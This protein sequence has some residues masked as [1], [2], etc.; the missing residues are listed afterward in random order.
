MLPLKIHRFLPDRQEPS[1]YQSPMSIL[2]LISSL[3]S[4]I[5]SGYVLSQF[6]SLLTR[7]CV[8][9]YTLN[10]YL[11]RRITAF[12]LQSY[13]ANKEPFLTQLTR[14]ILV[15]NWYRSTSTCFHVYSREYTCSVCCHEFDTCRTG[16]ELVRFHWYVS[17]REFT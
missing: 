17:S 7:S 4:S 15:H 13:P 9:K 12:D 1:Y 5:L 10:A 14:V 3:T 11:H 8:I 2:F 6:L 16:S